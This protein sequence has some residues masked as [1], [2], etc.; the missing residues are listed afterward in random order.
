M[1][2][3]DWGKCQECG[4]CY[5]VC[6]GLEVNYSDLYGRRLP[7]NIFTGNTL[8]AYIGYAKD[9]KVRFN[10]SSGGVVT[11]IL[12]NLLKKRLYD[13]ASVVGFKTITGEE[14][15]SIPTN[16]LQQMMFSAKSKY[17]PVSMEDTVSFI[18]DHPEKRVIVVATPCQ[19]A[20]IKKFLLELGLND[21]N[22][23]FCG[24]FCEK[25]LNM[26]IIDYY[27]KVFGE[28]EEI[29]NEYFFRTKKDGRWPGHTRIR[30]NSGRE[31]TIHRR[32][33]M[34]LKEYFQ[35]H[36]CVYCID[37][38]NQLAD[39]SFG[40]CYIEG[41]ESDLGK[42]NILVR[43]EKG[44]NAFKAVN[45][46][47]CTK[48][49]RMEAVYESQKIDQ[50]N[51]NYYYSVLYS[52]TNH[53]IYPGLERLEE[54]LPPTCEDDLKRIQEKI[55]YGK[56]FIE[57]P[58][59]LYKLLKSDCFEPMKRN[60]LIF[61]GQLFNKGSQAM[62]FTVVNEMKK[63]FPDKDIYL[64]SR[65][66]SRRSKE[67]KEQYNFKI[68]TSRSYNLTFRNMFKIKTPWKDKIDREF[69]EIVERADLAVDISG[70]KLSSQFPI[71]KTKFY[72]ANIAL[73]KKYGIPMY[74]LPQSLGPFNYRLRDKIKYY[75]L[76]FHYIK[77]PRIIWAREK[78]GFDKVKFFSRRNLRQSVDLVLMQKDLDLGNIFKADPKLRSYSIPESSVAIIPNSKVKENNKE[79]D[80]YKIYQGIISFLLQR[81]RNIYII[82]HSYEDLDFCKELKRLFPD[83]ER[84]VLIEDDLNSI[85]LK[86][87]IGKFDYLIASRYHSVI[88]AYKSRKPCFILGWAVK[89]KELALSFEQ[90][91][92]C[93]DIRTNLAEKSINNALNLLDSNY[94][95]ESEKIGQKIKILEEE[96]NIF[97]EIADDYNKL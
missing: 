4:K 86:E 34:Q 30:F 35:L 65:M 90:S 17:L 88:H 42:S 49:V 58:D 75:P 66:D 67:E 95:I 56:E 82:R 29:I 62:V 54:E 69:E 68:F 76:L 22:L 25:T 18:K 60:I 28:N 74:I 70:Y 23:L 81:D 84:V 78:E 21:K 71:D 97:H 41:E 89:Y 20:G 46:H 12:I 37:K 8:K 83:H 36:R 50:K 72:L 15:K 92:Y 9:K 11:S 14:V 55:R 61:E 13:Y 2:S 85:E 16:D 79:N 63:R 87:L 5:R 91:A 39:I 33:R 10:G 52:S 7:V 94:R 40:D 48:P 47:L 59:R 77:Y 80:L 51:E 32:V 38:L 1:P 19:I 6:P 26:N 57:E 93:F 44:M 73:C 53:P 43:T 64:I 31:V 45:R 3:I 24:L 27:Q 96:D